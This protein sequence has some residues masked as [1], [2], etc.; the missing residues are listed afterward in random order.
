MNLSPNTVSASALEGGTQGVKTLSVDQKTGLTD[1]LSQ[2]DTSDLSDEDAKSI[3]DGI[4]ELGISSS[5]ELASV[6]RDSGVDAR[7]LAQQAGVGG[8]EGGPPPGGGKGGPGGAGGPGGPG[9]SGGA[10]QSSGAKGPDETAV[11]LLEEAVAALA[12]GE[13]DSTTSLSDLLQEA[14]VDVTQPIV[15]FRA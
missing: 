9:G 4:K 1:L 13:E 2:Y 7:G 10:G 6:L 14:G 11:Q 8:K 5:R 3:V 15:D 12:E